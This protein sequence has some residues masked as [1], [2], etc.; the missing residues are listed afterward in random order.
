MQTSSQP[1]LLPVPFATGGSKQDIPNDSQIGITA[2]RAS[3]TDGFPPLTRTP[4]AA[5]GVPPFSTDFNGIFNDITAAIRWSQAGAGYPFNAD[6]NSSIAGYPKGAKIPNST[7]DGF[8]LNTVD[9]NSTN[10][11]N[12]TSAL[13]G[14]V[15]QNCYGVTNITGLSGSSVV[16]TTLQAS[17]EKL[18]FSGALTA[19]INVVVPAWIK[20]W[21]VVNNTTGAFLI[22]VKTPLVPTTPRTSIFP[23][24]FKGILTWGF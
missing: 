3:Y 7:L 13:T 6:F 23:S 16:L 8:W 2:G 22:T 4:L 1:K 9:G 21:E 20:K 12:A 15:P 24:L 18:V 19:N 14:W 5:G 11:E 10:P 17:R